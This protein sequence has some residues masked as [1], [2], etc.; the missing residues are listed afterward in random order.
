ME[1]RMPPFDPRVFVWTERS[2]FLEQLGI[3]AFL[4]VVLASFAA[5]W[6]ARRPAL[7]SRVVYAC[8]WIGALGAV[9]DG[10]LRR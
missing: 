3:S 7:A 6:L 9:L 8:V 4:V 1:A 5:P 2:P 10:A